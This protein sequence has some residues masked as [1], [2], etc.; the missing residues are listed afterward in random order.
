MQNKVKSQ[1]PK[2]Q[3]KHIKKNHPN[4]FRKNG[5]IFLLFL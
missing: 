2:K 5:K 4:K 1:K 3:L